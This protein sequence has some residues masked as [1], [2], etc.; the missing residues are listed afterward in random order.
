MLVENGI[1]WTKI[2]S[3]HPLD[4]LVLVYLKFHVIG[5]TKYNTMVI[6]LNEYKRYVLDLFTI[7]YYFEYVDLHF[8]EWL[9]KPVYSLSPASPVFGNP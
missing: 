9:L 8:F 1:L 5:A 6:W 4:D 3:S 2:L 7:L